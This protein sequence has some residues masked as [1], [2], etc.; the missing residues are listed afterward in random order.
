[1]E[2]RKKEKENRELREEV[3]HLKALNEG[4]VG[5]VH[6]MHASMASG[7][8]RMT[9]EAAAQTYGVRE[10]VLGRGTGG[11]DEDK[12]PGDEALQVVVEPRDADG[13]SIK[14]P[15]TLEVTALEVRPEGVKVPLSNWQI[16]PEKLRATWK[17]GLL[18]A[19]YS[20]VLPWQRWPSSTKVRVVARLVLSD[21]RVFEA[22]KDVTIRVPKAPPGAPPMQ[23]PIQEGPYMPPAEG[24]LPF[25]R[26]VEDGQPEASNAQA[27]SGVMRA[28]MWQGNNRPAYLMPPVAP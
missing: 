28:V 14:T 17:N 25:P 2:L 20:V 18:S 21:G 1:M 13:H 24:D 7:A 6:G 3:H 4:L 8:P 23:P 26:R 22:D 12:H 9:P 5:E 16:P 11:V 15:G 19:G 27:D 10:I